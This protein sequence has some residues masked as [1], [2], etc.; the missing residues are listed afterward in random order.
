M[1]DDNAMLWKKS[2]EITK[3]LKEKLLNANSEEEVKAMLGDQA[4]EKDAA[5]AWREIN[6]RLAA[7]NLEEVED[8]ELEAVSGGRSRDFLT[9]GCAAS[10]EHGSFCLV[11]DSCVFVEVR[12]KHESEACVIGQKGHDW[13]EYYTKND[14]AAYSLTFRRCKRCGKE[15]QF[16]AG[17]PVYE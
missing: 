5:R 11:N 13:G 2:M 6:A 14:G 12:Y 1:V 8:D 16:K 10:V 15:Q 17:K 4:T 9:E 3:E 7:P